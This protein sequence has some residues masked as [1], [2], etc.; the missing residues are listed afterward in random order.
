MRTP[1]PSYSRLVVLAMVA[2]GS[3][4][5]QSP[6]PPVAPPPGP[7]DLVSFVQLDRNQDGFVDKSEI[8]AGHELNGKFSRLDENSDGKLSPEEFN[9]YTNEKR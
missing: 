9:K 2:A 7:D 3:A 8:P 5:A 4:L 1:T 6:T